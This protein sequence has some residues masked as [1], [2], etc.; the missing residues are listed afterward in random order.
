MVALN[1]RDLQNKL[2]SISLSSKKEK[3]TNKKH[4]QGI[5]AE[6]IS[7]KRGP[8]RDYFDTSAESSVLIVT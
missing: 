4:R 1:E 7:H 3:Q 8:I 2:F 6:I 5:I